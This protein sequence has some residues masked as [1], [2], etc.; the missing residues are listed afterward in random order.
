[1]EDVVGMLGVEYEER[2]PV[3]LPAIKSFSQH[4]NDGFDTLW[5]KRRKAGNGLGSTFARRA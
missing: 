3:G 2:L 4:V 1:M 5:K